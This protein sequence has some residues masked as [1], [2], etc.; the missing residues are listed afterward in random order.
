MQ[1]QEFLQLIDKYLNGTAS[2]EEERLLSDFFDSFQSAQE[3]DESVL[4]VKE[5][6]ETKMLKRLQQTVYQSKKQH[7]P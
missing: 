2:A 1:Q 6:L 5:Q 4:G 7:H 3:W